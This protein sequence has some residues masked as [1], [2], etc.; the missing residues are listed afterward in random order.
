MLGREKGDHDAKGATTHRPARATP[1]PM[2]AGE[3]SQRNSS[4]PTARAQVGLD[5]LE[6]PRIQV[7]RLLQR[8]ERLAQKIDAAFGDQPFLPNFS[9]TAPA[10]RRRFDAYFSQQKK[11]AKLVHRAVELYMLTCGMKRDDKRAA[12]G[13]RR[14]AAKARTDSKANHGG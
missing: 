14:H 2:G 4:Q 12:R 9:P 8:L 7:L 3:D 1:R 5:A 6:K 10:N 13:H 11:V